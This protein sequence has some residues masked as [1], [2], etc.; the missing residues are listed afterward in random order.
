MPLVIF[1]LWMNVCLRHYLLLVLCLE[2][3]LSSWMC[4][5]FTPADVFGSLATLLLCLAQCV[6]K[7][8]QH[9]STATKSSS[10]FRYCPSVFVFF[11]NFNFPI[12]VSEH[13]QHQDPVIYFFI[14]NEPKKLIAA[15]RTV[16]ER[17]SIKP[18]YYQQL[19]FPHDRHHK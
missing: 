13:N 11:Y 17:D 2:F 1:Y 14:L 18:G 9:D 8:I 16:K 6:T 10:L 4:I 3:Q 5:V 15:E 7:L 19:V 12:H